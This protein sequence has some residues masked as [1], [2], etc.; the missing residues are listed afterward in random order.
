[1]SYDHAH[2]HFSGESELREW[3]AESG[4]RVDNFLFTDRRKVTFLDNEIE[5]R[6]GSRSVRKILASARRV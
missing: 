5:V 1:M 6:F 2:M 3:L 4:L